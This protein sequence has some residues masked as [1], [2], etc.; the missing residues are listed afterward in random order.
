MSG[1][2]LNRISPTELVKTVVPE[3]TQENIITTVESTPIIELIDQS[4]SQNNSIPTTKVNK[5]IKLASNPVEVITSPT[6][7]N[8]TPQSVLFIREYIKNYLDYPNQP[9]FKSVKENINRLRNIMVYVINHQEDAVLDEVYKFFKQNRKQI[10]SPE[11]ALQGIH[12]VP[13]NQQEKIQQ[14]YMLFWQ[15]TGNSGKVPRLDLD[16]ATNILGSGNLVSYI[17]KRMA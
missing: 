2:K 11:L 15:I 17:S 10:L 5:P 7:N 4:I 13:L 6:K 9:G 1:R 14:I 3:T 12:L 16:Y 8:T